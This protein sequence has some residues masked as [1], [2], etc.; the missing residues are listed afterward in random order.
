MI[1][2]YLGTF[3]GNRLSNTRVC[4]IVQFHS[5]FISIPTALLRS[6][7]VYESC[8]TVITEIHQDVIIIEVADVTDVDLK[9]YRAAIRMDDTVMVAEVV[10]H[11]AVDT[12]NVGGMECG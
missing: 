11:V 10:G 5:P 7:S 3:P 2:L 1:Q 8:R 12:A 6:L 4:E 9:N